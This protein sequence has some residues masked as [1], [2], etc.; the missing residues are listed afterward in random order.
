MGRQL[1]VPVQR[2]KS[3]SDIVRTSHVESPARFC[4]YLHTATLL[5]LAQLLLA[6]RRSRDFGKAAFSVNVMA[7]AFPLFDAF[8]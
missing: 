4:T 3:V 6:Q 8:A 1:R 5:L 2:L 7:L